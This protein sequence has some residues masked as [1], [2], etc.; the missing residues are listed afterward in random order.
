MLLYL[1]RHAEPEGAAGLFLGHTDLA[2]SA[3][4]RASARA[5]ADG[6]ALPP[7]RVVASDLART[8]ETAAAL[9]ARWGREVRHEP[10][11]REM[12]FGLWDGRDRDAVRADDGE[13]LGSWQRA[14]S[15]DAV[16]EGESFVEVAAR[17]GAWW[18]EERATLTAADRLAVVA[19]AG[20]LQALLCHLLLL[21][22]DRAFQFRMDY[23]R[24]TAVSLAGPRAEVLYLNA[25]R[26]PSGDRRG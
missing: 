8:S 4:G 10:R 23:A 14:W 25:D 2:L 1:I 9:A 21:P 22:L 15:T 3:V 12:H 17:V 6:W 19:H 13:R 16:P 24:V 11:L 20:S 7:T 18:A 5:L 26:V